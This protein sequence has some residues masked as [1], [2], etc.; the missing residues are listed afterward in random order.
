[1]LQ[2]PQQGRAFDKSLKELREA[3]TWVFGGKS[4]LGRGNSKSKGPEAAAFQGLARDST[5]AGVVGTPEQ[6]GEEE[7]RS[8]RKQG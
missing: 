7:T 5:E 2:Y 3:A 1:M 8:G 4:I 6:A